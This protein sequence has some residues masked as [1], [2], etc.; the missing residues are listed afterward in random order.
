[1]SQKGR[2]RPHDFWYFQLE[3]DDGYA[4]R[5]GM[6][7]VRWVYAGAALIVAAQFAPAAVAQTAEQTLWCNGTGDPTPDQRISGCTAVI[8]S[9]SVTGDKLAIIYNSRAIGYLYKRDYEHAIEDFNQSILHDISNA[10][11]FYNRGLAYARSGNFDRAIADFGHAISGF[12]ASRHPAYYKR[13]YFKARGNAYAGKD[14]LNGA[15]ADYDEAI[16]MD[17]LFARAYYNRGVAKKKKGD[18][19]G[20]DADIAKATE[21]QADIGP[22]Q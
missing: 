2:D 12:D 4:G 6:R 9:R 10:D 1:V 17:P 14:D 11:T 7:A 20:G 16:K 15:I 8:A 5:R 3:I 19:S 13:D 21:L 18:I 22:E